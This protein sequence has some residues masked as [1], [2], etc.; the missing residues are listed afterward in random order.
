MINIKELPEVLSKKE[1][2]RII[3]VT[4]NYKHK[5]LICLIYSSGLRVSE[6][7]RLKLKHIDSDRK[8]VY[9]KDAKGKKDR[10]SI[11]SKRA[12]AL[13]RRYVKKYEPQKWLFPGQKENKHLTERSLQKVVKK[14]SKKAKIK[15][16]VSVHTLRHSFA[17][18]LHENGVDIRYIQKLLGHKSSKTTEIYTHVS[19]FDINNIKSPLDN[20]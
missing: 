7:I 20:L 10:Y 11:L 13:L 16:D 2:K 19:K 9:I 3:N 14:A 1:I 4:K 17:T 8:M 12:I 6:V 15:K 5:A 18:H